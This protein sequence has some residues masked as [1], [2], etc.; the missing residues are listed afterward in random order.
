[1]YKLHPSILSYYSEVVID[2]MIENIT[3]ASDYF[4]TATH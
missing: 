1:M 3:S 4:L 2:D